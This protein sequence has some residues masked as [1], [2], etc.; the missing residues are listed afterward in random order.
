M[1]RPPLRLLSSL[2]GEAAAHTDSQFLIPDEE[3][4]RRAL[5]DMAANGLLHARGC[6]MQVALVPSR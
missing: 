5:H 6:Q 3:E 4:E 2:T 1:Q